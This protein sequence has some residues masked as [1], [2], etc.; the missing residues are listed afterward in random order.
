MQKPGLRQN[1]EAQHMLERPGQ[2]DD[3]PAGGQHEPALHL[4]GTF[5]SHYL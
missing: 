3:E 5:T 1:K 2:T 4:L